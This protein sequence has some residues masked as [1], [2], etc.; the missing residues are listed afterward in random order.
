MGKRMSWKEMSW[1][2]KFHKVAFNISFPIMI[3][4]FLLNFIFLFFPS[5]QSLYLFGLSILVLICYLYL[6]YLAKYQIFSWTTN[7]YEKLIME[8]ISYEREEYFN[9]TQVVQIALADVLFFYPIYNFQRIVLNV[10]PTEQI[11]PNTFNIIALM[12]AVFSIWLAIKVARIQHLNIAKKCLRITDNRERCNENIENRRIYCDKHDPF[13]KSCQ[14]KCNII[15]DAYK[16]YRKDN[17]NKSKPENYHDLIDILVSEGYLKKRLRCRSNGIYKIHGYKIIC[18][19][20]LSTSK[21]KMVN[22][23]EKQ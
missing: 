4:F 18:N 20:H 13:R 23:K 7:K 9:W 6:Q 1:R 12:T 19:N 22:E 16:R 10:T 8:L 2:N 15:E 14:Q 21:S 17:E 5:L 11:T 3:S